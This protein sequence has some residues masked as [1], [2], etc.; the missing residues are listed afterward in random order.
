M[1]SSVTLDDHTGTPVTIHL[2][3]SSSKT[4]SSQA[5]GLVGGVVSAPRQVK[6]TLPNAHGAINNTKYS[7][8]ST[9]T[10]ACEVQG[11]SIEDAFAQ[12]RAVSAVC[13]Q[14]LDYG[15]ALLKWTEGVSGLQLQRL[16]K[17]DGPIDPPVSDGV[18]KLSFQLQFF[19]EDPR[20]YSQTAT[21]VT[22]GGIN[23]LVDSFQS[24]TAGNAPIHWSTV[25]GA[26]STA[27]A[28]SVTWG[29]W[30]KAC[31]LVATFS[32]PG[33]PAIFGS[34]H[35][36]VTPGTTYTAAMTWKGTISGLAQ[37][38]TAGVQLAV[39]FYNSS[40]ATL[41]AQVVLDT[42]SVGSA[43]AVALS[44]SC[45]A[46][47]SAATAAV[48]VNYYN[49]ATSGSVT[50]SGYV[51]GVT[52]TAATTMTIANNGD[53]DTPLTVAIVA[54]AGTVTINVTGPSQSGT[55]ALTNSHWAI[56]ATDLTDNVTVDIGARTVVGKDEGNLMSYLAAAVTVW[57]N[58][59]KG[60]NTVTVSGVMWDSSGVTLTL[61]DAY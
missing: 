7:D 44:G 35:A 29:T 51:Q 20:A 1:L 55:V 33:A 9:I 37:P 36:T 15:P 46:P 59:E 6:S 10:L 26:F 58:A 52:L 45:V 21:T 2:D 13:Q 12:F 28:Q 4:F 61:R 57:R 41:G 16:V 54:P 38:S 32:A 42:L 43:S 8:G 30:I 5:L 27:L 25:Q 39:Q 31:Q 48:Q 19:A 14:T 18:A 22:S 23:S 17:L 3:T 53:R 50:F 49:Q 47:A 40:G 60:A 11:T 24:D 56:G 34:N